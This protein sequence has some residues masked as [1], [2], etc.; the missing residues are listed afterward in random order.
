MAGQWTVDAEPTAGK[1]MVD[2]YAPAK[3]GDGATGSF[4]PPISN[5]DRFVKGLRDPIDGGAQ[6]LTNV[7]PKSVVDAG[8]GFNN[9]L[10]DK[11]GLVKAIP[12]GGL[13]QSQVESDRAYEGRRSESG[14]DGFDGYRVLGNIANPINY[15]PG[16]LLPKAATFAGRVATGAGIG[17]L[18]STLAPVGDGDF[19]SEKAKQIG[20]GAV[21]GG[22]MPAITGGFARLIS[23]NASTNANLALLKDAGVKPTIGQSLGGRWNALEEK[24][25]SLPLV[26][27][28]ISNARGDALEQ[29]NNAAINRA[30]GKVGAVVKGSGQT[31]VADAGNA[32]SKAYDDALG[33]VKYLKFDQQFATDLG[34]LK[35]MAQ[36][37]TG[38]MRSK[39]N[40]K[41]DE[42]VG[43]RMSGTG[44][45]LGETYKKVDSEIGGLAA[46]YQKS[47]VASESELARVAAVL[48]HM[49]S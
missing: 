21:A 49:F 32:I 15:L 16:A 26:G 3:S 7:L 27:D 37:L 34:Q 18:T 31:A 24:M 17:A 19:A 2:D 13:N 38:P 33:Q 14:E 20:M 10:A 12:A 40:A 39:F 6:L 41:L 42:V 45:M 35:T 47:A 48:S 43:G 4:A 25:T 46:K 29:F 30:S 11:T 22:V 23:P 9:W 36:G 1:W 5:G 8:N 44:S 28:M